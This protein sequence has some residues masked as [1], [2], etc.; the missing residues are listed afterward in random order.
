MKMSIG[1]DLH[2]SQFTVYFL[3]EDRKA[4]ETGLYPT[5]EIGYEEFLSKCGEYQEKGYEVRAAVESTGNARYFRNRLISA[6]IDV[7]V[8]N[9]L[10]FKVVNESVKKTD[11]H[12]ART[13]AEF[14]EKDMLPESRLCSQTSEDIRRVLKTRAIAVKAVVGIKN[15]IHGLLLGYGIET[16]RGQL[17]SKKERQRILSGLVDHKVYGS[18]AEAIKPLFD[19]LD[20]FSAQVKKL[21]K[22]LESMVAEDKDVELLQTIPGVGLITATTLRAFIDDINRYSSPKKFASHMGLAPWVQNS[23]ETIHH[24][25]ITKRGPKD[26]RTAMVQCV[27][28]M[29]RNKRTTGGYRIMTRYDQMKTHKGSGK[30]IIATA[31]KLSTIIYMMLKNGEPFDPLRMEYSQKYLNMQAAAFDAAKAG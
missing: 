25:H 29:V 30:S 23:N 5:K 7:T 10:K 28:G 8:V 2:K 1:V 18:A 17:Q 19:T 21:E 13:L 31:R 24:G 3:A 26:M 15:Q 27:L 22:V 4:V 6:G 12:D 9:T 11:K 14:L 16:K 20:Q